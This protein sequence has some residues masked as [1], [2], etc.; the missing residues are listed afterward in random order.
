MVTTIVMIRVTLNHNTQMLCL[1]YLF[2]HFYLMTKL[3]LTFSRDSCREAMSMNFFDKQNLITSF[4]HEFYVFVFFLF[5]DQIKSEMHSRQLSQGHVNQNL[6][7]NVLMTIIVMIR[8]TLNH[9][10]Q[11]LCVVYL[12]YHFYLMTKLNLTFS[13]DSCHEAMSMNFFDEQN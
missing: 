3:N 8:V 6:I 13:R 2:Y 10:T 7:W 5:N 4:A 1:F 11:M 12:F 9:N